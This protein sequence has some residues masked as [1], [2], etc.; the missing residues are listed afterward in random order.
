MNYCPCCSGLLLQHV[1][2]SEISWFCRHCWQDMPV[3]SANHSGSLAEVVVSELS[4]NLQN[5]KNT[6]TRNY[7]TKRK[8]VTGW[9][10][11]QNVPA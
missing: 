6:N 4:T 9:I 7:N 3:F 5:R 8:T 1:C 11:V 10:G 2:G